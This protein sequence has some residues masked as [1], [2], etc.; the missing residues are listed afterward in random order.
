MTTTPTPRPHQVA[1][2]TD[3]TAALA[4]HDRTQLVMACGTGKTL[5]GRWHAQASDANQV[6]V[7][8]PSLALVAQT[9]REWRRA[10]GQL[11]AGWRFEALVVCSDPTTAA[12]VAERTAE[13]DKTDVDAN[14]WSAVGAE[15]TTDPRR[16]A[17]FLRNHR[18]NRPQVVFSTYHSSPV[19][20]QAQAATDVAFDLAICDEA[21]RL[22]GS[23]SAAFATVL[24]ARRIVARKRLFMT[25]TPKDRG[26]TS[27]DDPRTFG[28]VAQVGS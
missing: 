8:L 6:L 15:V 19:I 22:A 12:G 24:D 7:L 14:T 11:N 26:E 2:L 21:H 28:P 25:A 13:D 9:L 17:R 3:L 23:P 4:V 16:A 20:A 1:A 10:T 5:V 27:M 18:P